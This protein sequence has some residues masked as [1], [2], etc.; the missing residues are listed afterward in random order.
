MIE[1]AHIKI[2][3]N[4]NIIKGNRNYYAAETVNFSK[5]S[6]KQKPFQR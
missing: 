1:I 2:V 4:V 3:W 6:N 5:N